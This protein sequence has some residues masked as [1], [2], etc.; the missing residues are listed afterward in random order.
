MADTNKDGFIDKNELNAAMNFIRQ[1]G[2]QRAQQS[3][4]PARAP[5]PAAKPSSSTN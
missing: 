1:Q 4:A 3:S 2:R 5:T